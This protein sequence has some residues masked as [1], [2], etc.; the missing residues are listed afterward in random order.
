MAHRPLAAAPTARWLVPCVPLASCV[1]AYITR[2]TL[3]CPL[4]P[5]AQRINRF[6]AHTYCSITWFIQ[7]EPELIEPA[8]DVWAGH[9]LA[10]ELFGGPRSHPVGVRHAGPMSGFTLVLYPQALH[11]LTGLKVS[12]YVDRFAPLAD[13]LDAPWLALSQQ[14]LSAADDDARVALI[15]R[16]LEP[17]WQAVH[18]NGETHASALGDW[19]RA[20]SARAVAVAWG[21][22][23]RNIERR[24]KAWTGQP[25]RRLRRVNRVELSLVEARARMRTGDLSWADVAVQSGYADQAHLCRDMREL[26]GHSPT[27]LARKVEEDESFWAYRIWS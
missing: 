22:S 18:A 19:V 5:P 20:L 8:S 14:V 27:E 6:P 16:F 3:D 4:L 26:T 13:V 15:E 24:I 7:D 2:S 9:T 17:R 11:A 10:R 12:D 23:A 25:L 21:Q 1:R